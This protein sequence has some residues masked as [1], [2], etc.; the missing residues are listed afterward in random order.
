MKVKQF[1]LIL[2][3]SLVI[4]GAQTSAAKFKVV[5]T[6]TDLA[7]IAER[8]GGDDVE[9]SVLCPGHQDPHY[10]PA[11]PS[12]TRKLR[13]ADLLVYN[14]LEL[15][16][17][18]LPLLIDAA[19]NPKVKPGG[20]GELECAQAVETIL[21]VPK[22]AVDRSQGDIHPLGNPHYLLDPRHGAAVGILMAERMAELDPAAADSYRARARRLAS[23][24]EERLAHWQ[25]VAGGNASCPVI[26]Y[27]QHWEYLLAWLNIRSIGS[28]ENRPGISPSPQHVENIIALGREQDCV[29]IL[30]ATWD[31]RKITEKA[32]ALMDAPSVI[33]PGAMDSMEGT[34]D[35]IR[36]FDVICNK[37]AEAAE[38]GDRNKQVRAK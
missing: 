4:A 33:L 16:V 38:A 19:R 18:W 20:R 29:F 10:L 2:V 9:V 27:H 1:V 26:V 7:W 11:K 22:G 12:L 13:D 5:A 37:L 34:D 17:G 30:A 21:E 8:V 35:Y 28:I 14:G 15:E 36:M 31:N 24:I 23:E 25:E 3:G 6:L 32:A